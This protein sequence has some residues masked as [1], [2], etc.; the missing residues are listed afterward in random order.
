MGTLRSRGEEKKSLLKPHLCQCQLIFELSLYRNG[1]EG[2]LPIIHHPSTAAPLLLARPKI[3]LFF[4][5]ALILWLCQEDTFYGCKQHSLVPI[6]R[7]P[8]QPTLISRRPSMEGNL[9]TSLVF[10][11]VIVFVIV[12]V[13]VFVFVIPH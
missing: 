9:Q 11:T 1:A 2:V 10:I 6:N 3:K 12:I 8:S 5:L 4:S 7:Q 13:N